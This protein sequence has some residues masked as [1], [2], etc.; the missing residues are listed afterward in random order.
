MHDVVTIG[1]GMLRLSPPRHGRL[2]RARRWTCTCAGRRATWPATWRGW[3]ADGV[4][5]ASARQR[6]GTAV[7]GLLPGLRRGRRPTSARSRRTAR[8]ELHRVRRHAAASAAV[9]DRAQQCGQHDRAR[10]FRLGRHTRRHALAYT[11]GIL[12][13][14]SATCRE[15]AEEFLAAAKRHKCLVGFDVNYRGTSVVARSKPQPCCSEMLPQVD[16]LITTRGMRRWCSVAAARARKWP[17]S[18]TNDSAAGSSA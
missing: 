11:D 5:H 12:P 6:A 4:C 15:T 1:E 3:A 2:R 9:Y 14:L 10:R 17:G 8:R 13:G 7:A 16:I 18:C